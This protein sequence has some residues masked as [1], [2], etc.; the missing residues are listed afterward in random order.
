MRMNSNIPLAGRQVNALAALNDGA[1]AAMNV[2]E[3]L[4]RKRLQEVQE[5]LGAGIAQ[6]DQN[7]LNEL[8]RYDPALSRNI[9]QQV[10]G[11][12]QWQES[13][14]YR[15]SRD[16]QEFD[17][18]AQRANVGDQQW[19][20]GQD[21]RMRADARA[22]AQE[23]R[24]QTDH[25]RAIAQE[26]Q[27]MSAAERAAEA[28]RVQR[29]ATAL[30]SPGLTE[31]QFEGLVQQFDVPQFSGQYQ[32]RQAL[33]EFGMKAADVLR[34]RE[35]NAPEAPS[36]DEASIQRLMATG[37]DRETAVGIVDG[38]YV[39]SRDPLSEKVT[40]I[41]KATGRSI[42]GTPEPIPAQAAQATQ[43]QAMPAD[44]PLATPAP[45]GP[46]TGA[47]NAFGMEGFARRAANAVSDTVGMGLPFENE[48]EQTAFFNVVREDMLNSLAQTYGRQPAQQFMRQIQA[49]IPQP[50]T[51]F[52]GADGAVIMLEQL[53]DR[54][55]RDIVGLQRVM[56]RT[57]RPV[58]RANLT[59]RIGMAEI[60]LTTLDNALA[61]FGGNEGGANTTSSGV[62]WEVVE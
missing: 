38:R 47:E 29:A 24:S 54:F 27:T 15:Q 2:N 7:A 20:A 35:Q 14:D 6:G 4:R 55:Q 25:L 59:Q 46:P 37:V 8:A 16:Q 5:A 1:T 49:L 32:N 11:N 30:A 62:T 10:E 40:V 41:D 61:R 33:A 57:E 12:R 19:Q 43:G 36:A 60:A 22:Q 28:D 23:E 3:A 56:G 51:P 9:S 52:Q 21:L 48:A 34:M 50:G 13:F 53:R 18:R 58:D 26:A 42:N 31:E 17:Y 44:A 39:T 45:S